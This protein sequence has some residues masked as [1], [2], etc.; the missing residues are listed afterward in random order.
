MNERAG[1]FSKKMMEIRVVSPAP[2]PVYSPP[3]EVSPTYH[4]QISV[5]W[6]FPVVFT[7]DLFA[8]ENLILVQTAQR[9]GENRRH[10]ALVYVDSRILERDPSL[11]ERIHAY[12]EKHAAVFNL[13]AEVQ[14]VPGGEACKNDLRYAESVMRQLLELRMDRQSYVIAVGGG[15]LLD[16]I[17]FAA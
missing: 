6:E 9:L 11:Q 10:R 5:N 7:R 14:S 12:F 2:I 8:P 15:A 4:Q 16:A 3:M 13:A 17:G 1:I